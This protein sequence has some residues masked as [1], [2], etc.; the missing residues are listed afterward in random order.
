MTHIREL[1]RVADAVLRQIGDLR[2]D[3]ADLKRRRRRPGNA[4][5]LYH[6][7]TFFNSCEVGGNAPEYQLTRS[8]P[9]CQVRFGADL[10]SVWVLGL[11]DLRRMVRRP[12]TYILD[13]SHYSHAPLDDG[14]HVLVF[15]A[16]R[17]TFAA[18]LGRATG[19]P[20][21]RCDTLGGVRP[22]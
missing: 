12:V 9:R 16:N 10:F 17:T 2:Y 18:A 7:P 5:G 1:R 8:A 19:R 20:S 21:A 14:G 13:W 22:A 15:P 11:G 6:G 3:I 4:G